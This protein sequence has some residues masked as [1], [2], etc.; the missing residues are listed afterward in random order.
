MNAL[1]TTHSAL[2]KMFYYPNAI[3]N[4]RSHV[5]FQQDRIL[6]IKCTQPYPCNDEVFY[7][8]FYRNDGEE[9]MNG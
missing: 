3:K 2:N 1:F 5:H 4:S 9:I 8:S 7:I 6:K